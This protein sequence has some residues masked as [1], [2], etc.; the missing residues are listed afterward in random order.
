MASEALRDLQRLRTTSGSGGGAGGYIEAIINTPF[1]G[2]YATVV[3]AGGAAGTGTAI[4]GGAGGSG[5]IVIE[6]YYQ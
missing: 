5:Y 4:H 1:A 6:E 3:G 2:S